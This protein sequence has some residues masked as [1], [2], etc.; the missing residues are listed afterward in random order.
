MTSHQKLDAQ[1]RV[2]H[3]CRVT[4]CQL[5]SV[6]VSYIVAVRRAFYTTLSLSPRNHHSPNVDHLLLLKRHMT[7]GP[8]CTERLHRLINSSAYS[9]TLRRK[10]TKDA[11]GESTYRLILVPCIKKRR[12]KMNPFCVYSFANKTLLKGRMRRLP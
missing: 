1:L 7:I 9:S 2:N 10:A 3:L 11:Q 8:P 5:H 6:P 4:A 12:F